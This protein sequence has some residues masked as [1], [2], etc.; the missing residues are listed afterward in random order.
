MTIDGES[1]PVRRRRAP[2]TG[3]PSSLGIEIPHLCYGEDVPAIGSCRLCVVEVEGMRNLAA[4]CSHPVSAGMVVRTDTE[5]VRRA[6]RL[7]WS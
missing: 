7:N 1:R 5:R 2:S 6:R 3:R 4:S